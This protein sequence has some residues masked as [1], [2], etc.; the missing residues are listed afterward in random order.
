MSKTIYNSYDDWKLGYPDEWDNEL[1]EVD[2]E[3]DDMTKEEIIEALDY[4]EFEDHFMDIAI[5]YLLKKYDFD[6][7]NPTDHI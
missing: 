5:D 1:N 6:Y 2:P 3:L 7:Y 4:N